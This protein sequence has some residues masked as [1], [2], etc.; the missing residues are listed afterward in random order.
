MKAKTDAINTYLARSAGCELKP[1]CLFGW[2][3]NAVIVRPVLKYL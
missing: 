3:Q 1:Y 2:Q